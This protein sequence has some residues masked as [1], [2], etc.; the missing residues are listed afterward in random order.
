MNQNEIQ[1][2]LSELS[3]PS[4]RAFSE[5][6]KIS[7]RHIYG[8]RTPK[9]QKFIKELFKTE[10]IK[11]LD[12]FFTYKDPSYEEIQI[13][14]SLFG[15]VR[16]DYQTALSYL[17]RL[18]P[19][20]ESWATNDNLAGC[21][22]SLVTDSSFPA[23]LVS[24]LKESNPYDQR[25]GIVALMYHYL[26]E[27]HLSETLTKLATV[28]SDHYYVVMALGWAYAT[29]YCRNR[30]AT[31]SY[32]QIGQLSEVVRRKAIQKCI[33]SRLVGE[34]DKELLKRLRKAP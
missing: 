3:E 9:A 4:Y 22:D 23:Y 28:G 31:L 17:Q 15:L 20:N 32:L 30:E 21:L 2:R 11:A 29:A 33:E 26:D 24:L 7:P 27:Q 13:A 14:F 10:G 25:L 8:V 5:K 6:L 12:D 34:E 1:R 18:R 19:F 16:M